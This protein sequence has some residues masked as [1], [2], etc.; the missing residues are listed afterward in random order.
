MSNERI[1]TKQR[2][3]HFDKCPFNEEDIR[4]LHRLTGSD[5]VRMPRWVV[6]GLTVVLISMGAATITNTVNHATLT[7]N[8]TFLRDTQ[9]AIVGMLGNSQ[10]DGRSGNA[11][12]KEI[13]R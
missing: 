11:T 10:A 3:S 5:W 2:S 12:T 8:Q 9:R 1:R 7:A 6:G 4:R 13:Y